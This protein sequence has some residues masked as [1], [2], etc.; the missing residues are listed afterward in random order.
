VNLKHKIVFFSMLVNDSF[1][2][3]FLDFQLL[4]FA[5]F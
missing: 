1:D 3:E 4:D 2:N 5:L